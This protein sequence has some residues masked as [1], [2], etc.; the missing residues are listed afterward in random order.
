M[1]KRKKFID[2]RS[3][4]T[5]HLV[6]RSQHDPLVVDESAPSRV[7]AEVPHKLGRKDAESVQKRKEEERKYGIYFD[8]DYDYLQHLKSADDFSAEL[9]P[10]ERFRVERPYGKKGGRTLNL[11]S[12]VFESSV[13]EK[14]GVLNKAAPIT[15]P[16]L[17]V[18][19]DIAAALDDDFD[20]EDPENQ[21]EDDFVAMANAEG[22]GDEDEDGDESDDDE[23]EDFDHL[24]TGSKVLTNY[25]MTSSVIRRN[26]GL[27]LIDAQFDSIVEGEYDD[28]EIGA[29]D[30]ET[31]DGKMNPN[32]DMLLRM[33]REF[34]AARK[35]EKLPAYVVDGD[36]VE[37]SDEEEMVELVR[38][39]TDTF[40]CQS[41]LSTR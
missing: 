19:P 14:V 36:A 5:F 16:R 27:K 35:S 26:A 13:E 20:F 33:A 1:G 41:I 12:S 8:D 7:L 29:L 22:E 25:S 4:V 15:G 11:P 39:K 24:E 18:D 40:D 38:E 32:S 28:A 21:L 9:E 31:I 23:V 17:D 30:D 37:S 6:H 3:A 10:V 2:K 34:Q